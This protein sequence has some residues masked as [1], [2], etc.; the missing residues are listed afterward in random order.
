MRKEQL[1]LLNKFQA[2]GSTKTK[3]WVEFLNNQTNPNNLQDPF[4]DGKQK[5]VYLGRGTFDIIKVAVKQFFA[6]CFK[7]DVK[8]EV[9]LLSRFCHPFCLC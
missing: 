7:E 6:M 8:R 9:A 2:S 4:V 3:D 1:A 5:A